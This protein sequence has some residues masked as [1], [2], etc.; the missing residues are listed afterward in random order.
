MKKFIVVLAVS[1][2]LCTPCFAY[3]DGGYSRVAVYN[4]P[5]GSVS[6]EGLDFISQLTNIEKAYILDARYYDSYVYSVNVAYDDLASLV[7]RCNQRGCNVSLEYNSAV[8]RYVA[9]VEDS[10]F[11]GAVSVK[12]C[13]GNGDGY[14]YVAASESTDLTGTN[15]LL[16]AIRRNL[17]GIWRQVTRIDQA[18]TSENGPFALWMSLL[19]TDLNLVNLTLEE[20]NLRIKSLVDYT[21]V[22]A[23]GTV[24][25]VEKMDELIEA[26]NGISI[27]AD[28]ATINLDTL[29]IVNKLDDVITAING[30]SINVEGGTVNF[31]TN[32]I[33]DKLDE[34]IDALHDISVE[35]AFCDHTFVD[36]GQY[37][38]RSIFPMT[39]VRFYDF[40]ADENGW[41]DFPYIELVPGDTYQVYY[42]GE[43]YR[44]KAVDNENYGTI[45]QRSTYIGNTVAN[46]Q[47]LGGTYPFSIRNQL[48][49]PT[50][51]I[52]TTIKPLYEGR[53]DISISQRV[54]LSHC[55][56]CG[57][58]ED[59]S[60]LLQI[61]GAINSAAATISHAFYKFANFN[62]LELTY[63]LTDNHVDLVSKLDVIAEN[64]GPGASCEHSYMPVVMVEPSCDFPGVTKFTCE[65][66]GTF[67][68]ELSEPLGHE[69][70]DFTPPEPV[71]LLENAPFGLIEGS[72]P[73][74]LGNYQL[75]TLVPGEMY[76]VIYNGTEYVTECVS[77]EFNGLTV[78]AIGNVEAYYGT[79]NNGLPFIITSAEALG[80][81]GCIDLSGATSAR[82]SIYAVPDDVE[83][84]PAYMQ[85]LLVCSRCDSGHNLAGVMEFLDE[86]LVPGSGGGSDLTPV[87]TRMDTIIESLG[88]DLGAAGCEHVYVA[89]VNQEQTCVLP[90]LQTHTCELCGSSYS[91]ILESL[92]HDWQCTEHVEDELDPE[93]GEVI[94]S[95]YDIYTCS[96]CDDTYNDYDGNGAPEDGSTSITG[97]VSRVFEKIGSLVGELLAMGVRL[98]DKLL[99]GFD[100]IVTSFNEKTQQIVS[101]GSGYTAWLSGF[102]GIVPSDLQLALS[103]CVVVI[104]LGII[105]KKVV[106]AS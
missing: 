37:T 87:L 104:C 58:L 68:V 64:L 89:E 103:F 97:I 4:M 74:M 59:G 15:D 27:S 44:C 90:G 83:S 101:F 36:S 95:G 65:Y 1:L 14:V 54:S 11:F 106:F 67:R 102:W 84:V 28:G 32:P 7:F 98:L 21:N 60:D 63:L 9:W 47:T 75:I 17:E 48:V 96:I 46:D 76:T 69:W 45:Y 20:I 61:I 72:S 34:V 91:E 71:V 50:N 70:M 82:I 79:G 30:I 52:K 25:L 56:K 73:P 19:D 78:P 12:G 5:S 39:P 66:C 13:L 55:S 40:E 38:Y 8:D 22:I 77:A 53:P 24:M 10:T 16:D 43:L 51:E 31:D 99:T 57:A 80:G 33:T 35:G 6:A 94:S 29:P 49:Y 23:N 85:P 62:Y 88:A 86:R 92:G 105:G 81:S 93:T 18:L 2:L 26:V 3:A 41:Y 42:D 100:E